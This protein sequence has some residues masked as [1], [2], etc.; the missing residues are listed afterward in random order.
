MKRRGNYV[1]GIVYTKYDDVRVYDI[2]VGKARKI[3]GRESSEC[4]KEIKVPLTK[5]NC[6]V[7]KDEYRNIRKYFAGLNDGGIKLSIRTLYSKSI[8]GR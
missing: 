7:L 6:N 8:Q 3:L 5:N 4:G 1:Y 2:R